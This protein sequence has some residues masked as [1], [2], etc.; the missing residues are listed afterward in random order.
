MGFCQIHGP[1]D[2]SLPSCPYCAREGGRGQ[3]PPEPPSLGDDSTWVRGGQTASAGGE[4]GG[5]DVGEGTAQRG[6]RGGSAGSSAD[7]TN[8][9]GPRQYNQPGRPTDETIVDGPVRRGTLAWLI[10]AEGSRRGTVLEV[11]D[12]M[13]IG[14]D[15]LISRQVID[16]RKISDMHASIRI[17]GEQVFITDLDST[18]GTWVNGERIQ[19]RTAIAENDTVRMGDTLMML[20]TLTHGG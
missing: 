8:V 5:Y 9:P 19:S 17:E 3:R 18:N 20:K 2:A 16:D 13:R 14:R 4:R 12:G 15:T 6:F 1:Y 11:A 7:V 10:I